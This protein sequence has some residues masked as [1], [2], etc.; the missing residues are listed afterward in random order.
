[1]KQMLAL[2]LMQLLGSLSVLWLLFV[3]TSLIVKACNKWHWLN[4][5]IGIALV[6]AHLVVAI[7]AILWI[8]K[9][10]DPFG[11]SK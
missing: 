10:C 9:V 6:I 11:L 4:P 7:S 8:G 2:L 1:M 3:A 5:D